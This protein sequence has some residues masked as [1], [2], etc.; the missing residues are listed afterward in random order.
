MDLSAEAQAFKDLLTNIKN[1]Q[2]IAILLPENASRD[3]LAAGLSLYLS[4]QLIDKKVRI[5]YPK[6]PTVAWSHLIGINKV[7]Q[8]IG[9]KNFIVSL[10]YVEGSIDKVSYNIEGDKFNLVIEPRAG[11]QIFNEKNVHYSYSGFNAELIITIN[12][13]SLD[14]LGKYYSENKHVFDEK[15][16]VVIDTSP[17]N[18]QYGRVNIVYPAAATCEV[19]ASLLKTAQLP[20]SSDIATNLYDGLIFGSRNFSSPSV[21]ANTFEMAAWLLKSGARKIQPRILQQ[22]ELPRRDLGIKTSEEKELPPDWLKPKIYK[23]SSIL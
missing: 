4:L 8:Q 5:A 12:A 17:T 10:D 1:Q 7:I 14:T 18:K 19:A 2:T 6:V 20:I 3:A 13:S 22:E 9:S 11:S 21:S 15:P 16:A 23:G